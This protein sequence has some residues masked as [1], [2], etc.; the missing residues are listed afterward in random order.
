MISLIQS[1]M[2]NASALMMCNRYE[3]SCLGKN[4]QRLIFQLSPCGTSEHHSEAHSHEQQVCL[5]ATK[6]STL[7]LLQ[8]QSITVRHTV[9]NSNYIRKVV[10]V[11]SSK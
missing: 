6:R 11:E 8:P 1:C 2:I 9:T 5:K 4:E 3:G 7:N 10:N